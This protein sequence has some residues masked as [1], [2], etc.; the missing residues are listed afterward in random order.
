MGEMQREGELLVYINGELVPKSSA[1]ISVFDHGLLYGDGVFEGIRAYGGRVFKLDE[2]IDRLYESMHCIWLKIPMTKENM[3]QAILQT[4][5]ANRL[6]D[7]Y[8]RVIVTRGIGDLGL[9]PWKCSNPNVIIIA[10]RIQLFPRELYERGI[11]AVI[12]STRRN[13]PQA[14]D[15]AIK[16]LNY[17][18]NILAKTEAKIAGKQE[19]IMLTLDGYVA[20][21]SGE[22][23]FIVKY[24]S[25]HTPPTHL[26]ILNGITR[27]VVLELAQK[28]D[29]PAYET[30]LKPRDLYTADEC[31]LTGTG[32]EIVPVVM[33]DEHVIGDGKPGP[34]TR[35]LME[36]FHKLTEDEG[37]PI[38][39]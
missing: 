8:I 22:N 24:G 23:I 10:D 37:T 5:R 17:L 36:A 16:S 2:H 1:V 21:G 29:I 7:A 34:I 19:A 25:L 9:D 12:V 13:S 14:L 3:R 27:R 26:G 32:A 18:N 11:E 6:M 4:L 33:I 20:E 35:R 28:L 30:A 39:E 38:Y 15:P 31:F